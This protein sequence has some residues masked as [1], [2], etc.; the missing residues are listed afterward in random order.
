MEELLS[1]LVILNE[2]QILKAVPAMSDIEFP[3][4]KRRYYSFVSSYVVG[5]LTS[6]LTVPVTATYNFSLNQLP[7]SSQF[8]ALFDA[9]RILHVKVIFNPTTNTGPCAAIQTVIDYD[10]SN[11][12]VG[13]PAGRDTF[14]SVSCGQYFERNLAPRAALALYGGA[15]TSF[16]QIANPWT[17]CG[18]PFVQHYGLKVFQPVSL[19][20]AEVYEVTV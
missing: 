10:D 15:F 9:Y 6:S 14:M 16:G 13:S 11:L 3:T 18:N 7:D 1:K 4:L 19:F 12:L 5:T 20:A 2:Q 8:T 17:D